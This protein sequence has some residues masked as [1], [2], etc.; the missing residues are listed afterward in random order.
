VDPLLIINKYG[1]DAL[2]MGLLTGNAVGG[3][4]KFDEQKIKGYRNFAN[5]IWNITRFVLTNLEETRDPEGPQVANGSGKKQET[6]AGL[7][8]EFEALARDITDDMENYRL[9]LA[10][11]KI[12]H[13]IWHR[14]ADELLEESKKKSELLSTIYYLL[15]NSLKLLHPFMPFV[16][17]EIWQS[18][19]KDNN[20]LMIEP[21]PVLI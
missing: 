15:E 8:E 2:R 7:V 10:S 6:D 1:A 11:E 9:H 19:S 21:W 20:L 17:E 12:Y 14:L 16:T 3:D 5:K 18:L 13:Y 4:I